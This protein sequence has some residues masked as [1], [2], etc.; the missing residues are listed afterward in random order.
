MSL[1]RPRLYLIDGY[2]NIFRAFYAIRGGLSTSKGEP[3]NA[4][5][6]FVTMLRKLLREEKPELVGV[7]LDVGEKTFRSERFADY[8]ATR[9]PMPP[10]LPA[11]IARVREVLAAYRIPT[12][13]VAKYE[14]DD[15]LGTL[16]KQAAEAGYDVVLVSA[17]KDLMQLVGPGVF[18]YHTGREK[19]YDARA[20]EEDFGVPPER[21]ARRPGADGRHG[22]Q[23]A[24]RAG[25]RREGRPPA[26]PR[27]RL[28]GSAARARRRA[29]AQGLPRGPDRAPRRRAPLQG[30]GHHPLRPADRARHPEP[31]ASSRPTSRRCAGCSPS[32]SSSPWPTS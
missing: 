2:S 25:D 14:A 19:L 4:V 17:D 20:V 15:V 18:V 11:Q 8:K 10:D 13:E 12:L 29:V 6:G 5:F 3:T 1:S 7:A 26:D 31:C 9:A 28:A 24:G 21:R 30:A 32:S 22:R 23:R 16:A 27:A